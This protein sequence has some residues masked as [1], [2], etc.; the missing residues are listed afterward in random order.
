MIRFSYQLRILEINDKSVAICQLR[1][2]EVNDKSIATRKIL[3]LYKV[4][5]F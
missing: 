4:Y 1:L 3:R 5:R 2:P